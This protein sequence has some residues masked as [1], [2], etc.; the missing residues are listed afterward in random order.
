LRFG[1]SS[2]LAL[3]GLNCPLIELLNLSPAL[4]GRVPSELL[5]TVLFE[6]PHRLIGFQQSL[7]ATF[8][9]VRSRLAF[10]FRRVEISLELLLIPLSIAQP[11]DIQQSRLAGFLHTALQCRQFVPQLSDAC[12]KPF[13]LSLRFGQL[14]PAALSIVFTQP[15]H[16]GQ[17]V[18]EDRHAA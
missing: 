5:L 7:P 8:N 10:F 3:R 18:T 1:H 9:F 4:F 17:S 13:L 11:V 2:F 12:G 14:L 6:H 15:Q 16:R